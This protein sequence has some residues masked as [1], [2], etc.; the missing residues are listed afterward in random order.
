MRSL[1]TGARP[2]FSLIEFDQGIGDRSTY[3]R[4][5]K[6]DLGYLQSQSLKDENHLWATMCKLKKEK[7]QCFAAHVERI[8]PMT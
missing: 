8:F 7:T 4:P 5:A 1:P 3:V 6:H 2:A